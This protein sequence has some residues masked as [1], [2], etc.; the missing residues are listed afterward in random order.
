MRAARFVTATRELALAEVPVPA[1]LPHEVLVRVQACGVCLSDVHV[2]DGSLPISLPAVTLGHEPAGVVER[3]G[4]AVPYWQPG[5]RVVMAAGRPC[6]ACSNCARGRSDR[7]RQVEIMGI[8]FDGAWADYVVV[9]Y[10][11]LTLVP[12]GVPIEQAAILADAVSTPYAALLDR[13]QVRPAEAV[14]VWGVG[15]LGIH[16]VK[17]ARLLGAA[18]IVVL[19]P[20]EAARERAL[21]AGADAAIDPSAADAVGQVRAVT[22][23]DGLDVALDVVG[24][25]AVL[26]QAEQCLASA[27]RLVMVGM[28]MEPTVLGPGALFSL[29]S[30]SL[31]GHLG[32][33][34]EHLDQL[35]RLVELGRLDVSDSVSEVLPLDDIADAVDR[36]A[37][38][39]GDPVRLVVRP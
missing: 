3:V 31:L 23:G 34:K 30:Q 22:G 9:P 37:T 25:A 29:Q 19:D 8:S 7:C 35:V 4:D 32:Y 1:L 18:P 33:R 2:I 38:K 20:R 24:S 28:S 13:A 12:D 11:A 27:G 39:R 14:G 16:A 5:Q 10:A 21:R 17:L 26:Q 15:G 36:L 6:L